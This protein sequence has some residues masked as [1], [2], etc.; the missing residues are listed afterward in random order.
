MIVFS[1]DTFKLIV[2]YFNH[3]QNECDYMQTI[4]FKF[5]G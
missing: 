1:L 5:G 3:I 2:I 4:I